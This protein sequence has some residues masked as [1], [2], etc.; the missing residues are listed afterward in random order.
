M[1]LSQLVIKALLILLLLVWIGYRQTTWRPVDPSG[2]WRMP[3]VLAIIGVVTL[4]RSAELAHLSGIDIAAL[5]AELVVSCGIGVLMGMIS[6][7]RPMSAEAQHTYRQRRRAA[8][9][10]ELEARTGWIGLVLFFAL[11]TIRVGMDLYAVRMGSEL[12]ATT[13]V[14]LLMVAAN[15][16]ARVAVILARANRYVSLPVASGSY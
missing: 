10:V 1:A 5:L 2:M 4:G 9:G 15:R 6:K 3:V 8:A 13:G 7:F 11:I 12:S 16:A 14:I